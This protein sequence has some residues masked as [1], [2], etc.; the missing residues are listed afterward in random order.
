MAC[1]LFSHEEKKII[2]DIGKLLHE[3]A[4]DYGAESLSRLFMIYPGS[5]TY[6]T[7]K[8]FSISN[9]KTHGEKVMNALAKAAKD[10]DNLKTSLC[11]LAEFHGKKLLVDPQ[12]FLVFSKCIQMTLANHLASFSSAH[13]LAVDK[14]LKAVYEHLSSR[15]R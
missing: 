13:Q 9:L 5:K 4:K 12:N 6:F 2:H 15:Y 11:E 3:N 7:Y 14:F 10:V 8:D 1:E